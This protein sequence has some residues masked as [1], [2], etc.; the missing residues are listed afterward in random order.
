MDSKDGDVNDDIMS[1]SNFFTK[2]IHYFKEIVKILTK[3]GR[4]FDVGVLLLMVSVLM[5]FIEASK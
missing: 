1:Y 2:Y 3:K 4:M 5:V